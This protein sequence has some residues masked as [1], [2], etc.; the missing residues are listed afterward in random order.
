MG[1]ICDS[2]FGNTDPIF[3]PSSSCFYAEHMFT[4]CQFMLHTHSWITTWI[5]ICSVPR[6]GGGGGGQC[7][8]MH[9]GSWVMLYFSLVSLADRIQETLLWCFCFNNSSLQ[10]LMSHYCSSCQKWLS[11][12]RLRRD[13]CR[14]Y[15]KTAV[16]PVSQASWLFKLPVHCSHS[17][18]SNST[19]TI[20]TENSWSGT[21]FSSQWKRIPCLFSCLLCC[22]CLVGWTLPFF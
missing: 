22:K 1:P 5:M 13:R 4:P 21:I 9:L 18:Q 20:S 11:P 10:L 19:Q 16:K 15:E 6:E 12:L 8:F 17:R 2:F 3:I 7:F 14:G